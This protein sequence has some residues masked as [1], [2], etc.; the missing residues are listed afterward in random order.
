[1][2]IS[3]LVRS[4]IGFLGLVLISLSVGNWSYGFGKHGTLLTDPVQ[5]YLILIGSIFLFLV[6]SRKLHRE[7][8][9]ERLDE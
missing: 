9:W 5:I 6:S 2:K 4:F 7:I 8:H 1:M 3:I